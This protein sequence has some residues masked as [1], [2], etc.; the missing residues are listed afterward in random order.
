MKDYKKVQGEVEYTPAALT[1][2]AIIWMVRLRADNVTVEDHDQFFA[3]LD[4]GLN[5]QQ[6]FVEVLELWDSL[7]FLQP[8][9]SVIASYGISVQRAQK[10]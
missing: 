4:L 3:W 10:H 8:F 5:H 2:E 6:A 1:D 9:Y 7:A